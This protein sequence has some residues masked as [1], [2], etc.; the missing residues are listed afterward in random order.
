[1]TKKCPLICWS[2]FT[3]LECVLA[4]LILRS[5]CSKKE[6][7]YMFKKTRNSFIWNVF[8]AVGCAALK[9]PPNAYYKRQGDIAVVKCNNTAKSWH[10]VCRDTNWFGN[11]GN[12]TK[13]KIQDIDNS[14][15][16]CNYSLTNWHAHTGKQGHDINF[17]HRL[18]SHGIFERPSWLVAFGNLL[19]LCNIVIKIDEY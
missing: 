5:L 16:Q 15:C 4:L 3:S 14:L 11:I 7:T 17:S 19:L 10:L 2:S 13:G 12:C 18:L 1:M 9:P 8:S 6:K